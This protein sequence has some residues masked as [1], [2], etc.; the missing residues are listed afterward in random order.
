M[1]L[2]INGVFTNDTPLVVLEGLVP[3]AAAITRVSNSEIDVNLSRVQ[4]IDLST[5]NEYL[6]TVSQAGFADTLL[7]RFAP[8][9]PGSYNPAPK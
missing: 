2:V 3:P 1:I 6:L 9:Q 7:Y 4:G 8:V 5:M